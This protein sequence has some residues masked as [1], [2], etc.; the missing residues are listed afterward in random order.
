MFFGRKRCSRK[1]AVYPWP[2]DLASF[3]EGISQRSKFVNGPAKPTSIFFF[4]SR[5]PLWRARARRSL[6]HRWPPQAVAAL[7]RRQCHGWRW[8]NPKKERG[9]KDP[10]YRVEITPVKPLYKAI[11]RGYITPFI[12]LK[13]PLWRSFQFSSHPKLWGKT[14]RK[15]Y[16]KGI[17]KKVVHKSFS[18][19]GCQ[20]FF[21]W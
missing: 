5:P 4:V 18:F 3:R 8:E 16:L 13:G 1:Y 6:I 21:W 17:F 19:W 20:L 7:A 10:F 11:Y 12:T 9:P 15:K 14:G 2:I